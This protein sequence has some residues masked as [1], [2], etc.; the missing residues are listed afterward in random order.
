M[1]KLF[2]VI[3]LSLISCLIILSI[4]DAGIY[5]FKGGVR[6]PA[7]TCVCY[8]DIAGSEERVGPTNGPGISAYNNSDSLRLWCSCAVPVPEKSSIRQFVM[9]GNVVSQGFIKADICLTSWNKPEEYITLA[10][11]RIDVN[12]PYEIQEKKQK[13]AVANTKITVDRLNT[14]YIKVR[15]YSDKAVPYSDRMRLD[16]F[17]LYWN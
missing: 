14:Y 10:S 4:A 9:V 3:C 5:D 2:A 7:S 17:E 1:K 11:T 16:Y 15:L 13:K 12:T 8:D 6:I